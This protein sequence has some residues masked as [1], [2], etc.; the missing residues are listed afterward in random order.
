MWKHLY[1]NI[2]MSFPTLTIF[3]SNVGVDPYFNLEV[4]TW[5]VSWRYSIMIR[6]IIGTA[7]I[8]FTFS[9]SCKKYLS[10]NIILIVTIESESWWQI[11]THTTPFCLFWPLL[12]T[13]K[14]GGLKYNSQLDTYWRTQSQMPICNIYRKDKIRSDI[15]NMYFMKIDTQ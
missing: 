14:E 4:T 15:S 8:D 12:H 5:I 13:V 9:S 7:V 1:H 6:I 11:N 10:F 2:I 3:P